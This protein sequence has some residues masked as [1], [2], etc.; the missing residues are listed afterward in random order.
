MEESGCRSWLQIGMHVVVTF[1]S[2]MDDLTGTNKINMHFGPR[3]SR[4]CAGRKQAALALANFHL[5]TSDA[6]INQSADC[7]QKIRV[8]KVLRNS[9]VQVSR[10]F[11]VGCR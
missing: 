1:P 4:C 10:A 11:R 7:R 9:M 3:G 6:R 8:T 2:M 5:L